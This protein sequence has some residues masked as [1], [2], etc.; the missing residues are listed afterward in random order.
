MGEF[1]IL[2][3][4]SVGKVDPDD[5]LGIR[6][7]R[8]SFRSQMRG[9]KEGGYSVWL[10]ADLARCLKEGRPVPPKTVALTKIT[11]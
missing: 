7:E 4:H 8:D 6:I 3:Y 1:R 10:L 5:K 11:G 9:L 2:L